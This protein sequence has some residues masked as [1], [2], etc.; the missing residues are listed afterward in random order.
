MKN[1]RIFVFQQHWFHL[2]S[3][4]EAIIDNDKNYKSVTIYNLNKKLFVKPLDRHQDFVG[5]KL[6]N[7]PPESIIARYLKTYFHNKETN[8]NFTNV[9]LSKNYKSELFLG[10]VIDIDDLQ[11]RKWKGTALGFAVSSFLISLTKDSNPELKIYTKLIRNLELTYFQLFNFLDSLNLKNSEDE[12]WVCN[13]RPFHE[14]TVVEYARI[15]TIPI[16]FYEIG[17]DGTNQER[18]ILH[19]KSPHD[20]VEHQN[21][22]KN[23][24]ENLYQNLESVHEWF[25]RQYPGGENIF[26]QKFQSNIEID[27]LDN[28]FV[29]FSSS[30]DE[31]SAISSDWD[32]AWGKQ[33]NAV[34]ELIDFFVTRPDLKL[35]IRVHP[36]QKNKSEQDKKKWKALLSKANN[37]LI[38]NFDS[39]ID[40]YQLLTNAKGVITYGSTIGVEAAYLKKPSALLANSR[41]NSIIPHQY[42]KSKEDIVNWVDKVN[43]GKGP[44]YSEIEAC[45]FGSLMWGHYMNTAGNNWINIKIKKDFRKVNVGY[46]DGRSLKPPILIIAISRFIRF[47]RLYLI[48]MRFDLG[49]LGRFYK[50]LK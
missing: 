21:S 6:F 15:N 2:G 23:H 43:L 22:I 25:Q 7:S 19:E 30:D 16:K 44:D 38:Y 47:V 40:S 13:G 5:S 41:W 26:T 14:R 45:Y 18:W 9:K 36:N 50:R 11:K 42:L 10:E 48:E 32:S 49:Q 33:L 17:G 24:F 12:F 35:V 37:V 27:S 8:F 20:R 39:N 31:V 46:L 1:L 4:L 29:Y 28:Y 3:L 34:V